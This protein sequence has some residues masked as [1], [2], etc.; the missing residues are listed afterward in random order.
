MVDQNMSFNLPRNS[1]ESWLKNAI[2][3]NVPNEIKN[4]IYRKASRI[5]LAK[6]GSYKSDD[7]NYVIYCSFNS[8]FDDT[9]NCA[10]V[11]YR[12][13]FDDEII[14]DSFINNFNKLCQNFKK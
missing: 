6:S 1:V 3:D 5:I 9:V 12:K 8:N 10:F 7:G 2:S 4:E 11:I 14:G 13:N